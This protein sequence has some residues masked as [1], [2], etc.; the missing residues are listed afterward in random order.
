[1][2][3]VAMRTQITTSKAYV[4][5]L[6]KKVHNK[7]VTIR[8]QRFAIHINGWKSNCVD[9]DNCYAW[10]PYLFNCESLHEYLELR[11]LD[12]IHIHLLHILEDS[13]QNA[14]ANF[15][16]SKPNAK[17]NVRCVIDTWKCIE[18]YSFYN[19]SHIPIPY[20]G[21]FIV[22]Q[23]NAFICVTSSPFKNTFIR[24]LIQ[25]LFSSVP[26]KIQIPKS[27]LVKKKTI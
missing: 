20:G 22:S 2:I 26:E 8:F 18:W 21:N 12:N 9:N 1:M 27:L 14:N 23:Y 17:E 19:H 13:S 25:F 4:I 5:R 15:G 24:I 6:N 7:W 11:F 16:S 3:T 10:K